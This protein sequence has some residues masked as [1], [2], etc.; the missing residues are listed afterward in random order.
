[1]QASSQRRNHSISHHQEDNLELEQHTTSSEEEEE[2]YSTN[3]NDNFS[4]FSNNRRSNPESK[5]LWKIFWYICVSL[6]GSYI[7]FGS[8]FSPIRYLIEKIFY[9]R[10]SR[11]ET[12]SMNFSSAKDNSSSSF[13]DR[14]FTSPFLDDDERVRLRPVAVNTFV[15]VFPTHQNEDGV[16]VKVF[17]ENSSELATENV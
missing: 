9:K 11:E 16:F 3:P 10:T 4:Q 8:R 5:S 6:F 15:H 13:F 14:L 7:I 2:I 12:N 1:M 17:I